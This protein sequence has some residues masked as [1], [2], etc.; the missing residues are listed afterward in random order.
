MA[1]NTDL[2]ECLRKGDVGFF[3]KVERDVLLNYRNETG[4]SALLQAAILGQWSCCVVIH[5]R[6]PELLYHTATD[7]M[8]ALHCAVETGHLQWAKLLVEADS[9]KKL[10]RMVTSLNGDTAMHLAVKKN[11]L[12]IV[13]LL[14]DVDPDYEYPSNTSG[15]TPLYIAWK[16]AL[17]HDDDHVTGILLDHLA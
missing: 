14:L 10:L 1:D 2:I 16:E 3:E 13:K 15:H 4:G 11:H 8:T 12:E 6:C 9:S 7:G 17:S 5:K